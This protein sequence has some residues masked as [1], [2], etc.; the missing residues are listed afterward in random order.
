MFVRLQACPVRCPWCDTKHRWFADQERRVSIAAMMIKTE[1]T[2]R[3]RPSGI[4]E[5]QLLDAAPKVLE[6]K[7]GPP[8]VLTW[9]MMSPEDV[10]LAMQAFSARHVV[11]TGG[12]PALYR[13]RPR[14]RCSSAP[15]SRCNW[16]HRAPKP[17]R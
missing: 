8:P 13:L 14:L 6:T 12:E 3:S 10:L 4:S 7:P 17:F 11:I 16:R 9:V 5:Q 2:R 15:A 1:D